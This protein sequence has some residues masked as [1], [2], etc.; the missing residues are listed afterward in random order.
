M[1]PQILIIVK[2]NKYFASYG[3]QQIEVVVVDLDYVS[4]ESILENVVT[5]NCSILPST[6]ED[7]INLLST[8]SD[9]SEL[10]K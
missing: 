9:I 4:E 6:M 3:T 10:N 1:E 7:A 8:G 5:E 2:D